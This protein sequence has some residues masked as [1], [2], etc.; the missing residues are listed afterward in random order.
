MATIISQITAN[1]FFYYEVFHPY[2]VQIWCTYRRLKILKKK[3]PCAE[4]TAY[5]LIIKISPMPLKPPGCPLL[6][7]MLT[8]LVSF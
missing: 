3:K 4:Y 7:L 2:K 1:L 6:F 8:T 5:H